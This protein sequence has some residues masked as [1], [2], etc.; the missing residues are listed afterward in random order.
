MTGKR[1]DGDSHLIKVTA[2][3]CAPSCAFA[4]VI[5]YLKRISHR[6]AEAAEII[7]P[8]C[9]PCLREEH[10]AGISHRGAEATEVI[11]PLRSPCLRARYS[12]AP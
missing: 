7:P 3:L 9:S 6:G 2:T 5:N 4:V 1:T 8:L 10:Y 12:S 11:P